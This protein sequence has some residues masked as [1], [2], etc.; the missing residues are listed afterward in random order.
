MVLFLDWML[1]SLVS[2]KKG[3]TMVPVTHMNA[4]AVS[5]LWDGRPMVAHVMRE[6]LYTLN[7]YCPLVTHTSS[8]SVSN[9]I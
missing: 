6:D 5:Q 2:S 1:K 4:F 9:S 3:L 8:S 7:L